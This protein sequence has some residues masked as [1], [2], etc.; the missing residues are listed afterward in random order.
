MNVR[1]SPTASTNSPVESHYLEAILRA[2]KRDGR[3][4]LLV[5]AALFSREKQRICATR[6]FAP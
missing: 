3:D 5:A 1:I 2:M 6:G 4:H